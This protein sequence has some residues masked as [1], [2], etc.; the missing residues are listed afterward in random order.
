MLQ[1]VLAAPR[2]G[3]GKTTAACALLAALTARGL[4]PCAFKSGP[5]YIDPMFH[6]AVLGVESHNLDLFFSAPQTARAL[7]ARHAAGHG[8]AVVEGAMGY[9]DGLGGVT[10][11]ASAWQLADTLDLPALLVVRPKGASLTLAAELRGLTAFRTPHHIAGILLNDCTQGLCALLK[12]MLEKETGLP[13]VGCLP[14]LPEAAI[15]SRHL[16]LKTAAE[17]D[18]LQRKIQLLSDAAQQTIDWPLLH[19]LFDRPAPAA[20]PC[21]LPPPRV[22]LA[23]ARDAAFCFTYAE[24]LE[25]LRENGAELCF[26]SP[27]ADTALPDNIG[28]LY[29]PGGYPELYA[30]RERPPAR[31]RKKR[32]AG[33][34]AHR[35]RVRRLFVPGPDITGRRRHAPPDGGRAARAGLQGRAA[36]AVRLRPPDRPRRQYAVPRGGDPARPRVPSL[37]LH[38]KRRCVHRCQGKRA[39]V[40]VR[41]CQCTSLR[42]FSASLLGRYAA[43]E[44]LCGCSRTL[45]K[46]N[47][48]TE[49]ELKNLLAAVTPP[50][51]AA[52]AAAH[53]HW[54]ALA[55]PLG[56]LGRLES[57]VEDAAAL[58][59]DPVPDVSRR[60]V[61]VLCADN[62]VVAQGVSQTDASVTRA[63]LENLTARR[64]SVCR[65]A[66]AAHCDVVPVDM[67][68]A[69]A[70]V[71]GAA[72]C[73][74]AAGTADFTTGP[75]MTRAQAVQAI[76][77]GIALVRA[78]KQNGAQLLATGE[79]GIG[80]TTTSSAV[81]SV[82]LGRPVTEMTGRGAGLSD[83]G[84]HR[85]IDAIERGIARN[86]PDAAD[87]LGVLAALGGFDIAGLCGV[88]LGGALERL[89]IVM[90]GFISGVAA[91]CAVRLCPAAE[92]AVFASHVSSEPAA[93]IVLDALC[94][95]PLITA[96]LHLGEGTGAVASLPLWDMALAVYNG[97]YSFAEGG[98]T[99]Y[100]PQC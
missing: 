41:L 96:E 74:I 2:S 49:N 8:A 63:V 91:L 69:G 44:A 89:P 55:K 61:L 30:A 21:T 14:P 75:A 36:C 32:R 31:R 100:T 79:M 23:V 78:Q 56:G 77:A 66:A 99:P 73:R 53:A 82:L 84:L 1:L 9:Y 10:D 5:D 97:C 13:V 87:P 85:K 47:I 57:M 54:A 52:R 42:G 51:E 19:T 35:G 22:R 65:M 83:A 68:I 88:F 34:P 81:A 67:G 43:A 27:L 20:V 59:G 17:I 11:T 71:P 3:S 39:A 50:D 93:H 86:H 28:G 16:G 29:L 38:R 15:E 7:Y 46:G 4:T 76:A 33:R 70:P 18:D 48:M 92:K 40:G 80:N 62:G 95:K 72:D 37:G 98:I 24:T 25:A 26:F 45:Y 6:R 90:D 64:T 94:K 12:P 60:A 58:T